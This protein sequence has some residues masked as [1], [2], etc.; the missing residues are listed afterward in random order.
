MIL[1][2]LSSP[3]DDDGAAFTDN[4]YSRARQR[5]GQGTGVEL[6]THRCPLPFSDPANVGPEGLR[7]LLSRAAVVP[8]ARG[9]AR[10]ARRRLRR[11]GQRRV[12]RATRRPDSLMTQ[13]TLR[14]RVDNSAA[15]RRPRAD[16]RS[17]TRCH[18]RAHEACFIA[19]IRRAARCAASRFMSRIVTLMD[20]ATSSRPRQF[21]LV[22]FDWGRHAAVR[23]LAALDHALH[24]GVTAPTFDLPVPVTDATVIGLG[25]RDA[26]THAAPTLPPQRCGEL[27]Q[28]LTARALPRARQQ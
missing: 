8:V 1:C 6:A 7:R 21:D 18:H 22:V 9:R 26:L 20:P 14:P 12:G 2:R 27:A 10:M 5:G 15:H 11:Y 28:R 19:S 25:L 13:V 23:L 3:G 4:R 16:A 24:P 17:G